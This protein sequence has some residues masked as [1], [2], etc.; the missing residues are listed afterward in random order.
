MR[1]KGRKEARSTPRGPGRARER[2]RAPEWPP[3]GGNAFGWQTGDDRITLSLS[4][5]KPDAN[6]D[7]VLLADSGLSAV[8]VTTREAIVT[9][10]IV[11]KHVTAGG[12]DVAGYRFVRFESGV[13]LYYTDDIDVLITAEAGSAEDAARVPIPARRHPNP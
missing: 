11:D 5:L 2:Q 1:E 10:G 12:V 3:A 13:T 9:S 6:G 8:G 4:R 7:V